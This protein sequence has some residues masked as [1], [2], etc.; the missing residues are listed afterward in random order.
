MSLTDVC[1]TLGNEEAEE[2]LRGIF[3]PHEVTAS[4]FLSTGLDLEEQQWV[5]S[6]L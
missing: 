4:V 1:L 3:Q 2:A 5:Y 6:I